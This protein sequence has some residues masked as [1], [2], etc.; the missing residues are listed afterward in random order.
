[1]R[2]TSLQWDLAPDFLEEATHLLARCDLE[3]DA[4]AAAPASTD[5]IH[6]LFRSVHTF[7]GAAGFLGHEEMVSVSHATEQLLAGMRDGKVPASR[8][9]LG[10]LVA[11][12]GRL[13][14]LVQDLRTEHLR[15]EQESRPERGAPAVT[16]AVRVERAR[17]TELADRLR[18]LVSQQAQL[19]AALRGGGSSTDLRN[20]CHDLESATREVAEG[21]ARLPYMPIDAL[22]QK[23]TR[24]VQEIAARDGKEIEVRTEGGSLEVDSG[25]LGPLEAPLGHLVRNACDHGIESDPRVRAALGKP[26]AATLLLSARPD[27][28]RLRIEIADDGAGVDRE[29]VA[30]A[31]TRAGLS[32][33]DLSDD[34]ILLAFLRQPGLSTAREITATSGRGVGLDAVAHAVEG[35]GGSLALTSESGRG[36]RFI[37]SVPV[38]TL[39]IGRVWA[40]LQMGEPR[41]SARA[42]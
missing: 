20:R 35:M 32:P 28:D 19:S 12:M 22:F 25:Q 11:S 5:P 39:D 42:A 31:A 10:W 9:A 21:A 38:S 23:V 16:G 27:G 8:D 33:G 36:T 29:A 18:G 13:R 41:R 1:M 24:I 17:L 30:L 6:A 2:N 26:A 14:D 3:L 15:R 4:L 40:D 7:K 34:G 37:L